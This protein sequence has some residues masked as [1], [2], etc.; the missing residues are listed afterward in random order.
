MPYLYYKH[1]L[2]YWGQA[3][4]DPAHE[5]L[6]TRESRKRKVLTI[7][8]LVQLLGCSVPTARSRLKTW[9]SYTSYNHNGRYYTLRGIPRFDQHGLWRYK[10]VGFSKHGNLK[11]TLIQ[12]VRH[13]SG[14]LDAAKIGRLLGLPPRS[15]LSHF[16]TATGLTRERIEGRFIYFCDEE[17]VFLRQKQTREQR[18]QRLRRELP[19]D[20]VAVAVLA[21]LI[22][23]PDSTLKACSRRLGRKGIDIHPEAIRRLL[24]YHGVKKTRVWDHQRFIDRLWTQEDESS[25]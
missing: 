18:M 15:F 19:S 6:T 17:A 3:M 20:T 14:G 12:L 10:T 8:Q 1:I 16:R 13:S 25:R 9:R 24:E 5:E 2:N 7:G 4:I 22:N 21:D 23:H 11:Q